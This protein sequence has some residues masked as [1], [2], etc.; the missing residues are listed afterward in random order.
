MILSLVTSAPTSVRSRARNPTGE[1]LAGATAGGCVVLLSSRLD[2]EL[3][4][5]CG[6][7]LGD[8]LVLEVGLAC[9]VRV[10]VPS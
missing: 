3:S 5:S 1:R 4:L 6:E 2:P 7:R 9:S 10:P 8:E